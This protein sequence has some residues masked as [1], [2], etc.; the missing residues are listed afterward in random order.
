[1]IKGG[2]IVIEGDPWFCQMCMPL[3]SA[4]LRG[5]APHHL[6]GLRDQLGHPWCQIMECTPYDTRSESD[7]DFQDTHKEDSSEDERHLWLAIAYVRWK[8]S[9]SGSSQAL[10]LKSIGSVSFSK[11]QFKDYLFTWWPYARLS[12]DWSYQP[13]GMHEGGIRWI[14]G[15]EFRISGSYYWLLVLVP[16]FASLICGIPVRVA[17]LLPSAEPFWSKI[18]GTG[19][20]EKTARQ[21]RLLSL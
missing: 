13:T 9:S 11:E 2:S 7:F 20:R 10:Q 12:D 16:M 4:I 18:T 19:I 21:K 15:M 8:Y 14:S 1:M 6:W 3:V 17:A 5:I